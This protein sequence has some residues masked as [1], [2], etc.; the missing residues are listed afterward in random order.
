MWG[1]AGKKDSG[2]KGG[3]G[4]T[5]HSQGSARATCVGSA[6]PKSCSLEVFVEEGG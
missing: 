5:Y 4:E 1:Q 6:G 2:G 3:G